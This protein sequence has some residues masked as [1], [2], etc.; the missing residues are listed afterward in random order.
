[1]YLIYSL[2]LFIAL[3][4]HLPLYLV[5]TKLIRREPLRL[6]E[7][8]G[9]SP[10]P[11]PPAGK[12]VWLHAVSVG[13]VLSLQ[14]LVR[15]LK[16]EHPDWNLYVSVLTHSGLR[17]AEEKLGA[18]D[19]MFCIPF[20]FR[21][22]LGRYFRRLRPDVFVLVESE[23][24]PHLIREAG[25]QAAGVLLTNGRISPRSARRFMRLRRLMLRVLRPI[26]LFQ[27]QTERDRESLAG[28][29]IEPNRI[30]VCGNLKVEVQLPQLSED[31]IREQRASLGIPA[32]LSVILAGSTHRGEDEPLLTAFAAARSSRPA[33]R[34]I[35]APRH[36][37]RVPE[38]V[39]LAESQ[40]LRIQHRTEAGPGDT[41][42]VLVLDTIGELAR[43][44]ALADVAFIGGSLIPWGGQNLLEPAFY[45]KPVFF[46]PHMDNFSHLAEIFVQNG[47]AKQ[48]RDEQDLKAM[49]LMEDAEEL[50]RMGAAAR[51]TLEALRGATECALQAI[52]KFMSRS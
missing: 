24:W 8:L 25:R 40:G 13:E 27:V 2:L 31:E 43:L 20:D 5:R 48:V 14:H 35:L 37:D 9:F 4:V 39:K 22:I 12:T 47:A 19:H 42:D 16:Q 6:K 45:A 17:L 26:D 3:L 29:G 11:E 51:E 21:S 18:A 7:R 44:Y 41:W 38:V 23:L 30:Q 34:L 28:I 49:F 10:P 32:A 46:G 1:M 52:E 15:L 50:R 33:L 36:L